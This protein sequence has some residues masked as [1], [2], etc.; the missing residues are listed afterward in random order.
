VPLSLSISATMSAIQQAMALLIDAFHKY[1]GKEGDKYTL[2]KAELKDLLT[3]E[4][5]DLLGKANDK[6]AIDK[7]FGALDHDKSGEVDFQEYVT[8]VGALSVACNDF[9]VDY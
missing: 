4:L 3:N 8:M 5:G 2:S 1:S 6:T 7:I 9:F